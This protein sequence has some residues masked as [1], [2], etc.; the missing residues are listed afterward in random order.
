MTEKL[1]EELE[2]R[3]LAN[4]DPNLLFGLLTDFRDAPSQ[5]MPEDDALIVFARESIEGLNKKYG[6]LSNDTFFLFHR[7]RLWNAVDKVWMGYERKRGKLSELNRLLRGESK[8]RF[9]VLVGEESRYS[10][11]RYVVTLDTDTQLPRDA[12]WKLVGLMAHPL[13]TPVYDEKKKRVTD[14]YAIIQPR[15]AIS[16]HGATRSGYSRLHENDSGIDPYPRNL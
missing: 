5:V 14:G 6:S 1:V 8:E 3:F 11:V 13:N 9:S 2:V 7:P 4:R 10:S 12:A 15:I 16:L